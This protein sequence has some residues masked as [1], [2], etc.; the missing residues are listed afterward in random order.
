MAMNND[1]G[2][3]NDNITQ[4]KAG[5]RPGWL[6]AIERNKR[7]LIGNPD[8]PPA[9]LPLLMRHRAGARYKQSR[10]IQIALNGTE[11][12]RLQSRVTPTITVFQSC[13][14]LT[15]THR[16]DRGLEGMNREIFSLSVLGIQTLEQPP[17]RRI[18]RLGTILQPS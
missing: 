13:A 5:F 12:D 2:T 6:N 11:S 1:D 4:A 15:F 7:E 9:D 18:S 8:S 14:L 16:P 17:Q 10:K 3:G